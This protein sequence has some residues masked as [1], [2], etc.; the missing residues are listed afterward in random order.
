MGIKPIQKHAKKKSKTKS[1]RYF[2]NIINNEK[3]ER[4]PSQFYFYIDY[5]MAITAIWY[6]S[7]AF[8]LLD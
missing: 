6:C 4:I 2:Y 8:I 3:H 1:V 5:S 7:Q